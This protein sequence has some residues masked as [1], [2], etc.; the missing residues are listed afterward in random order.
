MID[1]VKTMEYLIF[2]KRH[3]TPSNN[4]YASCYVAK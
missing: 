2:S 3:G 1:D 4:T